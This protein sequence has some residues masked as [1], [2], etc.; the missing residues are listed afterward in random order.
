LPDD[1]RHGEVS[2]PRPAL[3]GTAEV[4]GA[5]RLRA[6]TACSALIDLVNEGRFRHRGQIELTEAIRGA[7]RAALLRLLALFA[8]RSRTDVSSRALSRSGRRTSS[9]SRPAPTS[10]FASRSVAYPEERVEDP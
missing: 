1:P 2:T 4:A 5:G 9:S 8:V 3:V 10:R 7:V 6:D